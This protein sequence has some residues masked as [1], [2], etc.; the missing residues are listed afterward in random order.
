MV[1][2]GLSDDSVFAVEYEARVV[3]TERGW[4]VDPEHTMARYWCSRGVD[5]SHPFQCV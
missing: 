5:V 3:R 1:K 2:T 4:Y